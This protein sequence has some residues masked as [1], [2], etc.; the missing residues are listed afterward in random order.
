MKAFK[1]TFPEHGVS[2]RATLLEDKAPKTCQAFWDIIQEPL[3]TNGRH[4]M[5]TGKEISVQ[6]PGERAASTDLHEVPPE[7]ITCFPLP[8]ELLYTFMPPYAWG[9]NPQ[10]IYDLGCF[11]GPDARTFFPMGWIA[12]NRFAKVWDEDF[13]TFGEMGSKANIEGVQQIVIERM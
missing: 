9:G 4:A 11:Y 8:G 2:I 3:E 6:L 7:N 1:L 5:Y 12:G 10:A 13:E